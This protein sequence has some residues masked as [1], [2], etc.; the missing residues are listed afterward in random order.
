MQSNQSLNASRKMYDLYL[1]ASEKRKNK[2][3]DPSISWLAL[4]LVCASGLSFSLGKKK[5]ETKQNQT[6]VLRKGWVQ[7]FM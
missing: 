4:V 7:L 3:A 1:E 5:K 2:R 6:T